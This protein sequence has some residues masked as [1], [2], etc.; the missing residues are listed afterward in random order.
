RGSGALAGLI[1]LAASGA[2]LVAQQHGP[3]PAAWSAFERRFDA[4]ADSGGIVGGSALL[5]RGGRIVARHDYGLADRARGQRVNERT[6]F[7]YGSITKTLTAIAIMQ[8]RDRGRLSL[9]DRV[10]RYI[11]ELRRLHDPYNAIDSITI[12]M[13]LTHSAGFQNPTWPYGEGKPWE[14]FEPTSWNQLVAMMPYQELHFRPG[15]RWSYSNPAYIYL[16]RII[17]QLTGDPW[18]VYVQKNILTPLGLVRS[19][20]GVTPYWLAADRAD[21]YAVYAD[22]AGREVTRDFGR[23]FDPGITIPNGGWNAPLAD[24]ATYSGFLTGAPPGDTALA[25][26]Y[27]VVLPRSTLQEMWQA[28]LPITEGAAGTAGHQS[29][30]LGFFIMDDGAPTLVGHTGSQAGFLAFIWVNPANRM[31]AIA[32]LNTNNQLP[33]GKNAFPGIMRAML[34]LIR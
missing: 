5:V 7:H 34:P 23:E 28:V 18:E 13:L 22:S 17:E 20:F 1:V 32:A 3:A 12:R 33:L 6:V 4:L 29:M 9:D 26:R 10:T 25:R 15:A 11:P 19:Y 8:L 27:D 31:V 2:P 16:A 30:G 14:P 21:S 24:L